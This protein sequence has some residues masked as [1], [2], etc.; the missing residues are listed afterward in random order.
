MILSRTSFVLTIITSCVKRTLRV[1]T[2]KHR[3]KEHQ[4]YKKTTMSTV[5]LRKYGKLN[6]E[7]RVQ[8]PKYRNLYRYV[9]LFFDHKLWWTKVKRF[10]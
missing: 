3:V 2:L 7:D 9:Y 10:K 1:M 6:L 4:L 8:F 5:K